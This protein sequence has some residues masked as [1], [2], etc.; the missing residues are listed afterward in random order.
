MGAETVEAARRA[1]VQ[2][3]VATRFGPRGTLR[4]H[5][6]ALGLDLL[7]APVNVA[8][9]PVFLL[10]RIGAWLGRR[11]GMD[12]MAGWLA[13]RRVFL[14]SDLARRLGDDLT[15]F[16][17]AMQAQGLV[18]RLPEADLRRAVA[19]YTETRNAVAEITTSAIVLVVGLGLF[20][21]T[22]PGIV[23]LAGPVA[24]MRAER[25]AIEEFALGSGLGRLWNG[26]FPAEP[27]TAQV[28]LTG[29]VLAAGASVVTAFAGLLAD[30]VQHWTGIH[31]RRLM[32]LLARLDRGDATAGVAR[33]HLVARG[34]D[35][36]D[37]ALTLWRSLRG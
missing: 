32:R 37:A 16:L 30:P 23:S 14:P 8:L 34:G 4:L 22:T 6:A 29:I 27:G 25:R 20:G 17:R 13:S 35:L 7:R 5:R 28:V 3:F 12:R 36:A 24:G 21:A 26:V 31:R 18:P 33:E 19:T 11:A 10:T 15:G 2:G 9:S 1:A